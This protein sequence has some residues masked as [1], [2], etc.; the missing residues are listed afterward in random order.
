MGWCPPVPIIAAGLCPKHLVCPQ[1]MLQEVQ[2]FCRDHH[3]MAGIY[4]FLRAW[5]PQKLES[6]RGC[7]IKN[8]V[9]LVSRLSDWQTRVAS[10]P[11]EV[12]TKGRLLLLSCHEVRG[13]MGQSRLSRSLPPSPLLSL[14]P[15]CPP[16]TLVQAA[17]WTCRASQ[18]PRS[19]PLPFARKV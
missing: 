5:G 1:G 10:V 6:M 19:Q 4:E 13:E 9:M 15:H 17:R 14:G 7:P 16:G 12:I 3:W 11:T 2:D 18:S 8:Y